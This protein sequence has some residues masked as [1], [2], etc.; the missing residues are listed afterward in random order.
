MDKENKKKKR[1]L[2][3]QIKLVLVII[4]FL[5]YI[6]L[7]GTKGIFVEEFKIETKKISKDSSGL[8]IAQFSDIHYG[9]TTNIKT[10]K[11]IVNKIN[12]TKPDIVIFTGDLIDKDYELTNDE[13]QDIIKELKKIKSELGNYFVLGEEDNKETVNMLNLSHFNTLEDKE[14]LI[15]LNSNIPI[16]LSSKENIKSYIK[17]NKESNIFKILVLHNPNDIN[18]YKSL[19]ID[20]AIAGHTHDGQINI[21]KL[22]ELFIKGKYTNN[23]QKVN[24]TKLYIN[25]GI[26]TS[27]I[28]VRLFNHPT[29]YLYRINKAS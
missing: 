8:K 7:I 5:L 3:W 9:S 12:L 17:E 1:K 25:P 26:G 14:Q 6:F 16:L 4:L 11:N 27:I 29:I 20:M 13:K 10:I 21:P 19:D 28:D 22:K 24:N 18:K 23:Y 15:Y 2:R